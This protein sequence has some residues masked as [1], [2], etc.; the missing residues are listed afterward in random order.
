[1]LTSKQQAAAAKAFAKKWATE[2][3]EKQKD[4]SFWN[5]LLESVYG[6]EKVEDYIVYQKPVKLKKSTQYIDAYIPATRV[7]IEHKSA[8]KPLDRHMQRGPERSPVTPYG[9]AL[10]YANHMKFSEKPR[11]IVTCNFREFWVYDM[12]ESE[13]M[14]TPTKIALANLGK[15]YKK[16]NF[17]V[18]TRDDRQVKEEEISIRAGALVAE[19]YSL[20]HKQYT[21]IDA[22]TLKSLNILCVRI[23]FC[24]YAEDAGVFESNQFHNYLANYGADDFG[25]RLEKLFEVL[26][27]HEEYRSQALSSQL[28]AFPYTNGGLFAEKITIPAFSDELR[29]LILDRASAAF[30]WSDISPTIFGALFESTINPDTREQGGMHYTSIENIHK[31]IDPLFLDG[32]KEELDGCL[33]KHKNESDVSQRRRLAA[34]QDRLASLRFLDPACGSGNF[35]T[36]TYLSLR[37]LENTVIRALSQGKGTAYITAVNP[38]KVS[39]DQFHGIEINDFAVSVASVAL[40]ISE[41]KMLRETEDIV[42]HEI[43]FLPLKSNANIVEGNALRVEWPQADYIMG[44]PPFVGARTMDA[45]Q[46]QDVAD[47]FGADWRN[48][49]NLDYVCCWYKRT[50]DAIQHC[51]TTRAALVSTNS[52]TQGDSI[53]NLWQPLFDEGLRIHFAH[54]TF[55][56]DNEAS[57]KAHVH[58]VIVGF[59]LGETTSQPIIYDGG[60]PIPAHHINAYLLD[61]PDVF[62]QSRNKPLCKVPEMGIGN[63]PIDGGNYLFTKE[64]ME[65]FIKLEPLSESLFRP[66]YGADE[67][68]Q[69]KPRYCLWLGDCTPADLQRMPHCMK[70]IKNVRE[71]RLSS[72]SEGTRKLAERPTRFH[73]ENMP[74]K[75]F[76]IV[77]CHSSEQRQYIPMGFMS[78]DVICSNANL[79]IS[80]ATRYHFG[81]LTSNVHMAWMRAVCG[82][83]EMRYRYSKDI[84]YNN[85]PWPAPAPKQMHAIEQTAQAILDARALYP[86]SSLAALYDDLTMPYEL[87]KAHQ[88]NDRAVMRAYGFGSKMSEEDVVAALFGRYHEMAE[89]GRRYG[90]KT[91]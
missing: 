4:Q 28:K 80:D 41:A 17:L 18:D 43:E 50:F 67:F 31:A 58:C 57:I 64:S 42:G 49:G 9:Q 70:R 29:T 63:K 82:R 76:I 24:L 78:P 40:W 88:D 12:E 71:L 75:E 55:R 37:E 72:R 60:T 59:G 56:W 53:A 62:I 33:R 8:D 48:A 11:W 46:K 6:I 16:L 23:V 20:L 5:H 22:H 35:L 86:D 83:L 10:E 32:L 77:P 38:I 90:G 74:D 54:R 81:V 45:G 39:I 61:A 15:E 26:N 47:I 84:V 73:V 14:R 66:F 19:M 69:Q 7:L 13:N 30:D 1:M 21:T 65:E 89:G 51:Q 52:I 36:E 25:E 2:G 68:I 85:F 44:N 91:I 79:M 3:S 87:R 34:F 27:T